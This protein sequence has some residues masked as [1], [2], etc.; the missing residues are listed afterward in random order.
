MQAKD[1]RKSTI[2]TFVVA[3]LTNELRENLFYKEVE[4]QKNAT[5]SASVFNKNFGEERDVFSTNGP[6]L[7]MKGTFRMPRLKK[8]KKIWEKLRR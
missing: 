7:E 8:E 3:V 5:M 4:E 6:M 2:Q 1:A